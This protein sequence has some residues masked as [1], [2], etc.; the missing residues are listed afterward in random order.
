[1]NFTSLDTNI[2]LRL[3]LNDVPE[4]SDR[5]QAFIDRSACYVTD[6]VISET[7][8][9]LEKV[10]RLERPRINRLMANLLKLETVTHN[11]PLIKT[12]F[13]MYAAFRSLSFADCYSAQ[14]ALFYANDLASFDKALIR[15]GGTHVREPK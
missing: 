12:V 15:N 8:F 4:Q 10:Y 3:I 2:V 11:E 1:M 5:A 9:V 14:E 7:V 6:V 13:T